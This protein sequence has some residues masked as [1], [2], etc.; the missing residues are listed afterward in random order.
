MWQLTNENVV[1]L[2]NAMMGSIN[3]L[4]NSKKLLEKK[5]EIICKCFKRLDTYPEMIQNLVAILR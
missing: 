3:Y 4:V 5:A 1:E 2:R